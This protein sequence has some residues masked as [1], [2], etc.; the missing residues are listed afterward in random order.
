MR[1]SKSR[2]QFRS[3]LAEPAT[4]VLPVVFDAIS[5]RITAMSGFSA[6]LVSGNVSSAAQFGLPD[7]GLVTLTEMTDHLRTLYT[8]APLSYLV[9]A[10]NGFGNAINVMRCVSEY[11]S[12]GASAIM[13]EDT[14]LPARFGAAGTTFLSVDEMGRK[15][16]A[17][18]E[19][20]KDADLV[21][22]GRTDTLKTLGIE[23]AVA[24]VRAYSKVGVDAIFVPG[25]QSRAEF[26]ALRAATHLPII[27]V[28][29]PKPDPLTPPLKFLQD[30]G[31]GMTVTST[32]PF[33]VSVKA[34]HDALV[35]I[36]NTGDIGS[37]EK[38]MCTRQFL[39]E[40]LDAKS[41]QERQHRLLGRVA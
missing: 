26:D 35:H 41:F 19:A 10:D 34:I 4:H 6:A 33:Q 22:V 18:V 29:F 31:V 15:L 36:K 40:L 13:F 32:I 7:L 24:R 20:R 17:A 12:A 3:M 28:G 9:D 11:E 37:L 25:A 2:Q 39:D 30:C 1:Q 16:Q 21:L 27:S 23:E 8:S 14:D 5:A 38:N